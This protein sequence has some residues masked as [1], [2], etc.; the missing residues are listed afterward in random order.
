MVNTSRCFWIDFR[1]R[2]SA[3][4]Q[5]QTDQDTITYRH[6]SLD[7]VDAEQFGVSL[8]SI[9]LTCVSLHILIQKAK[10]TSELT[11]IAAEIQINV[12]CLKSFIRLYKL[13]YSYLQFAVF[14]LKI[15]EDE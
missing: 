5:S 8:L 12:I 9:M 2:V 13:S 10:A 15:I 14:L 3:A 6:L 4:T 7:A 11:V 1:L